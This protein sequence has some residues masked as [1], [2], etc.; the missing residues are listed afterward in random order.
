MTFGNVLSTG[1]ESLIPFL[2]S[3]LPRAAAEAH[4]PDGDIGP[5]GGIRTVSYRA[6]PQDGPL[7]AAWQDLLARVPDA[8]V[9]HTS[10]WQRAALAWPQ[11]LGRLVLIAVWNGPR[12]IAVLPLQSARGARLESAASMVSDYLDPLMEP[13]QEETVWRAIFQFLRR[14][15]SAPEKITLRNIRPQSI[16]RQTLARISADEGFAFEEEVRGSTCHLQ[17]PKTWDDYLAGLKSHD[18]KE[19]RRKLTKAQTQA[20]AQLER[21]FDAVDTSLRA[22][23]VFSLIEAGGGARGIKCRLILRGL[24]A[25]TGK[26]LAEQHWLR[27]FSVRLQNHTSAGVITF[28]STNGLMAWATGYNRADEAWSPGIVAFGMTIRR[29]IEEGHGHLDLLRGE[30]D[31]KSRLGAMPRPLYQLTL[32]RA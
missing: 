8:T 11:R 28:R 18:R 30:C 26:A 15:Q 21:E 4:D 13:G 3:M 31:Y 14:Y 6:W 5:L 17:L 24:L 29:A 1:T 7:E 12:L 9:F 10:T 19:L 25:S 2:K 32:Q 23:E 16:C 22:Q 27:V 20:D